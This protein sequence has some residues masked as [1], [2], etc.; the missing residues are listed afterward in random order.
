MRKPIPPH[1]WL[2]GSGDRVTWVINHLHTR[3]GLTVPYP[4]DKGAVLKVLEDI[5]HSD[6]GVDA[7]A[8]IKRAWN[9]HSHKKKGNKRTFSFVLPVDVAM[10]LKQQARAFKSKRPANPS[11]QA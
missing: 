3:V 11:C 2:G 8:R 10:R 1:E 6:H 7:F 5:W 4:Q 9:A